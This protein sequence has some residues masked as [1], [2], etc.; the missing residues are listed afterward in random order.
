MAFYIE[1]IKRSRIIAAILLLAL[2]TSCAVVPTL[3]SVVQ[4]PRQISEA[5][6]FIEDRPVIAFV[7]GSGAA[8]GFAHVGVLNTL[9]EHGIVAD[10]VVG[11]S[12]GSVV[13]SLYCGGIRGQ[14]LVTAAHQLDIKQLTDW[15]VPNR[16]VVRGQRLQLYVNGLLNY[17]P[18]E[19]LQTKFIAVATDLLDGDLVA[20]NQ[21]D[22]GMATRASSAIPGLIQPVMINGREYVDGG[23]VSQVPVRVARQMGADVIIAVDVSKN[24]FKPEQLQSTFAVMQQAIIIMSHKLAETEVGEADI[25]IR[26]DVGGIAVAEFELRDQAVA[27]GE[28][29]TLAVI[30]EIVQLIA[31]KS[32]QKRQPE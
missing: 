25:L 5:P 13:G 29:A 8:R 6:L 21:G 20:F 18:I 32:W 19:A 24:P 22:T 17:R 27:A 11:T 15:V 9:E 10:I 30:P 26:P 28:A 3:P 1:A 4:V 7:L 23:L 2:L 31:E 12:A 16:G 14:A